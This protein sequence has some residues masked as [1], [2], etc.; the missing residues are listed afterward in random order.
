VLVNGRQPN[1]EQLTSSTMSVGEELLA[2]TALQGDSFEI[3]RT[4]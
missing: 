3:R 4:K 1:L 2:P